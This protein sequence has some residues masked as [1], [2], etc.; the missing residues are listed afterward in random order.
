[1]PNESLFIEAAPPNL[2]SR[3]GGASK[4]SRPRPRGWDAF[5]SHGFRVKGLGAT[6]IL[7]AAAMTAP[8]DQTDL[9]LRRSELLPTLS[10]LK[11]W[12]VRRSEFDWDEL[13]DISVI[14]ARQ[15]K[16]G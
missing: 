14:G 5:F 1:M 4:A 12:K 7:L 9:P 10:Q 16:Q 8:V 3:A 6:E 13:A 15:F 2:R 11:Q